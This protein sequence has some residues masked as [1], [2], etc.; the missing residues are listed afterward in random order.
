MENET[1]TNE[2][3]QLAELREDELV[4][5]M[6]KKNAEIDEMIDSIASRTLGITSEQIVKA[7]EMYNDDPRR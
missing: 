3:I 1:L 6:E 7:K 2:E 4:V 5:D